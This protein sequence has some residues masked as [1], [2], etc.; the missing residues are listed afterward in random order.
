MRVLAVSPSGTVILSG[1]VSGRIRKW[2]LSEPV[3]YRDFARDVPNLPQLLDAD[4]GNAQALLRLG[5]WYAFRGQ[6]AWALECLDRAR[7]A[8]ATVSPLMLAR[9]YWSLDRPADAAREF[10]AAIANR[11]APK[12][13]LDLCLAAAIERQSSTRPSAHTSTHR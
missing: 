8:G 4:P 2:D 1:D 9:V 6:D 7:A 11:E 3:R 13:Y 12:P 10:R 5:E